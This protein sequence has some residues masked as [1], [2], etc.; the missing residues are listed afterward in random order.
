MSGDSSD[1]NN[2][3]ITAVD[4]ALAES[5]GESVSGAIKA[6]LAISTVATDP[7]GFAT[8]LEKL[9]GGTKVVERKIMR[10]LEIMISERKSKPAGSLKTD[11]EDFGRFIETCRGQFR[12]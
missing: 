3:L 1:F 4:R 6:C 12:S 2:V 9:T 5:M 10:N 8:K 7:K 11:Q